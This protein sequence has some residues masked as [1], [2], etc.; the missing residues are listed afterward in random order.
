MEAKQEESS[1]EHL[2]NEVKKLLS[3][4]PVGVEVPL[5]SKF[6]WVIK[7]FSKL[8][9]KKH[10]CDV[11]TIGGYKWCMLIFPKGNSIDQLSMYL[12][13]ANPATLPYGWTVAIIWKDAVHQFT[14][15]EP[16]W[17]FTS[18]M[19]LSELYDPG[20]GYLVNDTCI[21]EA[22]VFPGYTACSKLMPNP[23]PATHSG[24]T[25][26][27]PCWKLNQDTIPEFKKKLKKGMLLL[28]REEGARYAVVPRSGACQDVSM[29]VFAKEREEKFIKSLKLYVKKRVVA[30]QEIKELRALLL[31]SLTKRWRR[32][33]KKLLLSK[34]SDAEKSLSLRC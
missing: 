4:S 15:G 1:Q 30:G 14:V 12:N 6:T 7:N 32:M 25:V 31:L 29:W 10:Y 34:F 17:G 26:S 13:V 3:P 9:T 22:E 16:D 5:S 24:E 8:K 33:Q 19:P 18:F 11:F 23:I 28:L 27:L 21:I 20:K 2:A